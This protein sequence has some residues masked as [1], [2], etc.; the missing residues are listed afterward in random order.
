MKTSIQ[1]LM[2]TLAVATGLAGCDIDRSGGGTVRGRVVDASGQPISGARV[3]V[4]RLGGRSTL[5]NV[6][7]EFRI[8]AKDGDRTLLAFSTQLD[9]GGA[10]DVQVT[11]GDVVDAGDVTITD[12]DILIAGLDGGPGTSEGGDGLISPDASDPWMP[13]IYE[14]PPPPAEHITIAS[15]TGDYADGFIDT[16]GVYG[17]ADDSSEQ[18]GFDFWIPA[19]LTG[20]GT[21]SGHVVNDYANGIVQAHV[22]LFTY[23]DAE[24]SGWGHYYV[25]REGDVTV[26]VA[27]DGD[28]DPSTLSFSFSG[29]NLV[30][31]YAGWNG[32]DPAFTAAV[33][34][35]SANG[36]AWRYLPPAPPTEDVTIT[37]FVADWKYISLCVACTDGGDS[38]YVYAWDG[39]NQA[40]VSLYVPVSALTLGGSAELFPDEAHGWASIYTPAGGW[41]YNLHSL[42]AT[43]GETLASGEL[44]ELSIA[45]ARFD[46]AAGYGYSTPGG[47]ESEGGTMNP[48][49][50]PPP[51]ESEFQLFIGAG[52]LSSVVDEY[53]NVQPVPADGVES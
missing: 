19:D 32:I 39:T 50:P 42:T 36:T 21:F 34:N 33:G 20:G 35:A 46:Y 25:L 4:D 13:C 44:F 23:A 7:G 40:D 2:I 41:G 8:A 6:R 37:T 29:T 3:S 18:A 5:T 16:W 28:G 45:D 1:T 24:S 48:G 22:G 11:D 30:F 12:C 15:L 49:E 38:L 17:Y 31:E 27:D 51:I 52:D 53:E 47:D 9:A 43:A 10:I 14:P 26:T